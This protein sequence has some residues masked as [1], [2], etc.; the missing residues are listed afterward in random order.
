MFV[1]DPAFEA[2]STPLACLGLCEARLQLDARF[3]WLILIP[4]LAGARELEDLSA[5]D[6]ARLIEEIVLAGRAVRAM[7]QALGRPV[8]KLNV[9][10]LGNLT[11]Q[12]HVHV[13]GRRPD[14]AA[15]PGSVW[16]SGV[17]QPW[18]APALAAVRRAALAVFGA[19]RR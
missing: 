1:L 12:L 18:P 11:P 10:S 9:G 3:P 4:R 19:S 8:A 6:R 2:G 13:V 15:W 14:D 5:A 7:G 17:A 16:G